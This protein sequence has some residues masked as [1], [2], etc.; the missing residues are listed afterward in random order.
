MPGARSVHERRRSTVARPVTG[1]ASRWCPVR[2]AGIAAACAVGLTACA[3]LKPPATEP[4]RLAPASFA[5]A[6]RQGLSAAVGV[7]GVG[8][9]YSAAE[10]QTPEAWRRVGAE[11]VADRIG[12]GFVISGAEGLIVTASH[13]VAGSQRIAVRLPDR[14]IVAATLVGEDEMAD[15]ALLRV[16]LVLPEPPPHGRSAGLRPGD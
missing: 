8:L 12:A 13:A 16:P 10:L 3:S 15:I 2:A 11:R 1:A 14:R 9:A 6:L 5:P 7:F 4:P